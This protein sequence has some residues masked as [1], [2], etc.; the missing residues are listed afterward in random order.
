[1]GIG[2]LFFRLS[3]IVEDPQRKH[4][5]NQLAMAMVWDVSR[6]GIECLSER[7][8][9]G[10]NWLTD[11]MHAYLTLAHQLRRHENSQWTETV[12]DIDPSSIVIAT[13]CDYKDPNHVLYGIEKVS[14]K[15]RL[16]YSKKFNY[17]IAFETDSKSIITRYANYSSPVWAAIALPLFLLESSKN[18]TYVVSMDCDALFIDQSRR[19]E[20]II[21][22]FPEKSLFISEDGRGLS[23]GNWIVKNSPWSRKLLRSIIKTPGYDLF[24][25]KDQFGFLWSLLGPGRWHE[26]NSCHEK[27][28]HYP[29]EVALVPQRLINAYPFA[30][31]R[32]SHHCFEDGKDFIV[33]FIT[34]G[35]QSREMAWSLLDNF[36]HR[37]YMCMYC[38]FV[39][40]F[41][42]RR[43]RQFYPLLNRLIPQ[44]TCETSLPN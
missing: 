35:S 6:T 4:D 3:N 39:T 41:N 28:F 44:T 2:S 24:D 1:M 17:T 31:C 13:V 40:C 23:G 38:V 18:Y 14:L 22:R 25:L 12:S 21:S 11:F 26:K 16:Q 29:C 32:P 33:S 30:L 20:S 34:L 10:F 42:I 5:L 9:W 37:N 36:A 43:W 8:V 15:N 7:R 19:I 27:F